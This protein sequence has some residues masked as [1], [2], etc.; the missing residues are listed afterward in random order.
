MS[1]S[2]D[3]AQSWFRPWRVMRRL[4]SQGQR[5]DRALAFLMIACTLIFV[6]Y[7]P[8]MQAEA[9]R[10]PSVP[11]DARLGGGM[12]AWLAV[13]PLVA[14]GIAAA[15]H[16]LARILGGKGSFYTARLALF[17]ALLAASPAWLV[18]SA[19][20]VAAPGPASR[21]AAALTLA[22][23]LFIWLSNLITAEWGKRHATV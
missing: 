1:V 20:T 21:G 6:S 2:R 13:M 4:M 16:I 11:L 5:E 8:Q 14:Y 23:T 12:L 15:S 18:Q 19:L 10:D 7:W 17:W 22:L 3:I 9:A